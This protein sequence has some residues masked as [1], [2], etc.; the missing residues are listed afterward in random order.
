MCFHCRVLFFI[1]NCV[2]SYSRLTFFQS[3]API[4][5]RPFI[6]HMTMSELHA[7]MT[8]GFS[9]IAGGVMAAYI[10]FGVGEKVSSIWFSSTL[11]D[12]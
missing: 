6:E 2:K 5:V 4:L 12:I 7:M 1:V 10:M 11:F 8:V 3:E 9:T